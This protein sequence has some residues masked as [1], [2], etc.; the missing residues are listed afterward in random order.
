MGPSHYYED[1]DQP[2]EP[3]LTEASFLR[4]CSATESIHISDLVAL[5]DVSRSRGFLENCFTPAVLWNA[6]H[7]AD[8]DE[9]NANK[10]L[11]NRAGSLLDGKVLDVESSGVVEP[12]ATAEA[13]AV[14][15]EFAPIV[16][17]SHESK[18]AH[19]GSRASKTQSLKRPH[20]GRASRIPSFHS[21][22]PGESSEAQEQL[23]VY[24]TDWMVVGRSAE[25]SSPRNG[26]SSRHQS[27]HGRVTDK[28]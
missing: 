2:A 23:E 25:R 18:N 8:S 19:S 3:S 26:G 14:Q 16:H 21:H 10:L 9:R 28:E 6:V 11:M 12:Q 5:F 7:E 22:N 1:G 20:E 4:A 15:V 27:L 13:S 24:D 17:P